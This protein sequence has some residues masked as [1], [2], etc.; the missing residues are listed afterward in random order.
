MKLTVN[1]EYLNPSYLYYF[2]KSSIGQHEL[3][4]NTSQVGVPAIAS[5]TTS[6]KEVDITL[7]SLSTQR[8]IADILS[9]LDD[10]IELNRQINTTLEAIA[11]A[12]SKEWCVENEDVDEWGSMFLTEVLEVNPSRTLRQS[13]IA[14]YLDMANM[15]TQGHRALEWIDRPFGSGTKFINGDTL[16][17]KITPCLENGKTA[18]VDFLA[19]GQTGWGS[20]EYIIFRP[21][22]PLPPEY[23][24][25]LA[26]TEALRNHAIQNMIGTS[27]RQ[28]V[29]TSCFANFMIKLP[30][31]A[32][33]IRFGNFAKAIMTQIKANDEQSRILTSL[34]LLCQHHCH[35]QSTTTASLKKGEMG[36]YFSPA[37]CLDIGVHFRARAG[38]WSE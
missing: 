38:L 15:P 26:R 31:T 30:P 21:K 4:K 19:E 5:P 25:Y 17:A 3:L 27:G 36:F 8:R 2:F 1:K 7:P 14:P 11:Q 18:F 22:P 33:A 23:G 12:I 35:T 13:D 37:L 20:T 6:L 24:Y 29:P 16:L 32:L 28:R 9:A 34:R 10:K